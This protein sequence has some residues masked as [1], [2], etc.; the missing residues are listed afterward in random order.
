MFNRYRISAG[1]MK[2]LKTWLA[3]RSHSTVSGLHAMELH[4]SK[5][6]YVLCISSKIKTR[7]DSEG[8]E[9]PMG[10]LST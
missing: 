3:G 6:L 1:K 5:R 2:K 8:K 4:A 10:F 7:K 9:L